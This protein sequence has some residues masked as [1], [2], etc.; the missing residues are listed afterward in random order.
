MGLRRFVHYV[1]QEDFCASIFYCECISDIFVQFL[2]MLEKTKDSFGEYYDL[3]YSSKKK[4]VLTGGPAK[5]EKVVDM[6]SQRVVCTNIT[7]HYNN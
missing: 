1:T 6:I 5:M 2:V 7:M 4:L 3:V